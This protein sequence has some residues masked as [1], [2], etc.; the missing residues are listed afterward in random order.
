MG[1]GHWPHGPGASEP[2]WPGRLPPGQPVPK[3]RVEA[4]ADFRLH[5]EILKQSSCMAIRDGRGRRVTALHTG[6]G[7]HI[8]FRPTVR[9]RGSRVRFDF[10][11]AQSSLEDAAGASWSPWSISL[12]AREKADQLGAQAASAQAASALATA[13]GR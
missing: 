8:E 3:Q 7:V 11:D 6:A 2:R 13:P 1:L 4:S 9:E 5:K 10:I 12:A